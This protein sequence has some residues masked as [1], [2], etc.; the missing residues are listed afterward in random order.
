MDIEPIVF[1]AAFEK[2]FKQC[3]AM[4]QDDGRKKL[5]YYLEYKFGRKY[6]SIIKHTSNQRSQWGFVDMT[7]GNILKAASWGKPE[8]KHARGNIFD[9]DGGMKYIKWT[10]PMYMSGIASINNSKRKLEDWENPNN[11]SE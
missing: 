9:D 6:I 5:G 1:Q 7:N 11:Y 10:G 4:V 2:W 3:D 8:T